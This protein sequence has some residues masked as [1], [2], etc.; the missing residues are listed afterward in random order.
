MRRVAL[1]ILAL[2]LAGALCSCGG[3][4]STGKTTEGKVVDRS[5]TVYVTENGK[6]YHN[7]GCR[8]LDKSQKPMRKEEAI[9]AGYGPCD[10][11][12]P[13]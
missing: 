4:S 12:K 3:G 6:K 9:K 1:L 5:D 2:V 7:D 8:F 11:C 13:Y 10:V